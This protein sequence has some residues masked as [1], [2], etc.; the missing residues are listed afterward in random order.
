MAIVAGVAET[1]NH[2]CRILF[3]WWNVGRTFSAV[4][5]PRRD[6]MVMRVGFLEDP[7]IRVIFSGLNWLLLTYRVAQSSAAIEK[8]IKSNYIEYSVREICHFLTDE[9]EFA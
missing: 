6:W 7:I 1:W 3:A 8:S 2:K 9:I 5:L 4:F